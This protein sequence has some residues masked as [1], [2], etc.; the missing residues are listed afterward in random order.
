MIDEWAKQYPKVCNVNT[1]TNE[2]V[3]RILQELTNSTANSKLKSHNQAQKR[4][5]EYADESILESASKKRIKTQSGMNE[6][7]KVKSCT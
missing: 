4:S 5:N 2:L 7:P 3:P 1:D 6:Y